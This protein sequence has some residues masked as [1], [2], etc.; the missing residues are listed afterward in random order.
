MNKC[1][2][3]LLVILILAVALIPAVTADTEPSLQALVDAGTELMF[4]TSNVTI[5]GKAEFRYDGT[6]FKTAEIRYVQSDYNSFWQE[7]LFTPRE[8]SSDRE[9]GFTVI[10]N[11]GDI[12]VM[13]P[14]TPGAYRTGSGDPQNTI[15]RES[16][17]S[18][19]LVSFLKTAARLAEPEIAKYITANENGWTLTLTKEQTPELLNEALLMGSRFVAKRLFNVDYD[20]GLHDRSDWSIT[21]TTREIIFM[22]ESCA[23]NEA[24]VD[25]RFDDHGRLS[26]ISGRAVIDLHDTDQEIHELGAD[27]ELQIGDY[28]T[29]IVRSFDPEEYQVILRKRTSQQQEQPVD[30]EQLE[31]LG[32]RAKEVVKAAGFSCADRLEIDNVYINDGEWQLSF[33]DPEDEASPGFWVQ[34]T[35]IGNVLHFSSRNDIWRQDDPSSASAEVTEEVMEQLRQFVKLANPAFDFGELFVTEQ[36]EIDD[37]L[38]VTPEESEPTG[39][40]LIVQLAPTPQIEEYTCVGFG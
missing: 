3:V 34:I 5:T 32:K 39:L 24:S 19:L 29:S 22:T 11:D 9:T 2:S 23:V 33:K 14:Y 26:E 38:Y 37:T 16:L 1:F 8:Y 25:F 7:K 10:S 12:A 17:E 15:I 35:D 4:D 36:E 20:V 21:S 6:R 27:F 30:T 18:R 31:K 28:G 13:E 40:V